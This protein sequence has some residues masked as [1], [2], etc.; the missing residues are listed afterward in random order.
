MVLYIKNQKVDF[1]VKYII[2]N[3][4]YNEKTKIH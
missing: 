4:F 3:N 2:K 1:K